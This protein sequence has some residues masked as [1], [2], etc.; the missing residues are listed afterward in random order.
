MVSTYSGQFHSEIKI[1]ILY[2]YN[3]RLS[4]MLLEAMMTIHSHAGCG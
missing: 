1:Y 2:M 4:T 3:S